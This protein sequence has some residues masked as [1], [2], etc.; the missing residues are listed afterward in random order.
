MR[1]TIG[2]RRR[3]LP[4]EGGAGR[5]KKGVRTATSASILGV[6]AL[7]TLV[8]GVTLER[9]GDAIAGHIGLSGSSSARQS[10]GGDVT[11]RAVHRSHVSA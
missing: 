9:G 6:A 10:R 1:R 3:A 2:D 5:P 11:A 8:L 4:A 7:V